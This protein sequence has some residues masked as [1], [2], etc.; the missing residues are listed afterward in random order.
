MPKVPQSPHAHEGGRSS[1]DFCPFFTLQMLEKS[2]PRSKAQGS[3][4]LAAGQEKL[5]RAGSVVSQEVALSAT[6]FRVQPG[7]GT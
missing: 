7:I 3:G 1:P 5:V 2:Q 6:V 4:H